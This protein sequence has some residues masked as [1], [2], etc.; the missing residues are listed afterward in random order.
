MPKK[1]SKAEIEEIPP[2]ATMGGGFAF[3]ADDLFPGTVDIFNID[4]EEF[5]KKVQ[6]FKTGEKIKALSFDEKTK[7]ITAIDESGIRHTEDLT[8][9]LRPS[10]L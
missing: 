7:V 9:E 2:I 4:T 3:L 1:T 5:F 10:I 6:I 8:R